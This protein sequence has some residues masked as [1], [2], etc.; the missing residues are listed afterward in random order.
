MAADDVS[1]Q[2]TPVA[3]APREQR[4]TNQQREGVRFFVGQVV[5]HVHERW[6]GVIMGWE[7]PNENDDPKP[8]SSL[9]TKTYTAGDFLNSIRYEVPTAGNIRIELVTT[10][11]RLV[12][13]LTD[14][15]HSAG[16]YF[17]EVNTED[18][19]NATYFYRITD[20]NETRVKRFT[21]VK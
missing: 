16:N 21:I 2:T 10:E 7:K 9:T 17:L 3:R 18:L 14:E 6:R 12:R 20:N 11:G 19:P 13:V 5:Q 8:L 4:Q 15:H 1:E